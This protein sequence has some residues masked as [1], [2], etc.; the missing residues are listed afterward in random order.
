MSNME[1]S[2]LSQ[3]VSDSVP[4]H[5]QLNPSILDKSVPDETLPDESLPDETVGES[6]LPD[7]SF[8]DSST[9]SAS[10]EFIDSSAIFQ[11]VSIYLSQ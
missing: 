3:N 1:K 5:A 9:E 11:L 7:S 2:S 4:E 10:V 8:S 6:Y